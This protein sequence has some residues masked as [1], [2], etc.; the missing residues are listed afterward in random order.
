MSSWVLLEALIQE[1]DISI[2]GEQTAN[3]PSPIRGLSS[4]GIPGTTSPAQDD[5]SSPARLN[6]FERPLNDTSGRPKRVFRQTPPSWM[7]K[8]D[9]EQ[10]GAAGKREQSSATEQ[11]PPDS[12]APKRTCSARSP[13][14][15]PRNDAGFND[16]TTL[17]GRIDRCNTHSTRREKRVYRKTS[18]AG[19]EKQV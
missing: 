13:A 6:R 16:S 5:T 7:L 3:L 14:A 9:S 15:R 2:S 11:P 19:K 12:S 4:S 17:E 10:A 18:I 8:V 1:I